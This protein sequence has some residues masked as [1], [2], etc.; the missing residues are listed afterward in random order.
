MSLDSYIQSLRGKNIAVIGFGISN[1]PLIRLLLNYGCKVTVCDKRPLEKIGLKGLEIINMGGKLNLG[2]GYLDHLSDKDIIFRT[3]GLM[4][5]DEHLVHAAENGSIVT[6]EMELFFSLCPCRTIAVTGSDGKTTTTTIINNL[7]KAA[8]YIT[9]I[10]GNIGKPLLCEVDSIKPEDIAVLEL[11]SFQLHSMICKPEIAVVTNIVP[12]HLD[13]HLDYNDYINAKKNIFL[14]QTDS[15]KLVLNF[16]D[17]LSAEF[18]S[19]SCADVVFFSDGTAVDR[20]VFADS[21]SIFRANACGTQKIIDKL[22]GRHNVANFMAAFAATD[23]LVGDCVCRKIAEE[24]SGVEHRLEMVRELNGVT[25]INDSIASSPTRTIAAL[26]ALNTPP[27]LIAGGY[28]KHLD[29]GPLGDEINVKAKAVVLTG[30]TAL[31]IKTAIESSRYYSG[32]PLMM[33]AD[34]TDAVRKAA[35][36]AEQ[37]DIVILSPASAS[38]D[39]FDN[40]EQRGLRFK[41]IIMELNQ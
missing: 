22:P 8:G 9:H 2:D 33:E 25:Y 29:Y 21:C 32:I 3:P 40:F 18:A 31:S 30:D 41:E 11:S 35:A 26:N 16:R 5:F 38:F 14:R 39:H 36:Y 6:S 27:I 20:G 10:G 17:E 15:D 19:E 12:N 7:L 28:D 1:E 37:G 23:G 13:K 4:P 34:F 24:F